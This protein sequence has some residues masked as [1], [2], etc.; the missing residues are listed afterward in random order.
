MM[1]QSPGSGRL[2]PVAQVSVGPG[3]QL[4]H[5]CVSLLQSLLPGVWGKVT[6]DMIKIKLHFVLTSLHPL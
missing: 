5:D 4:P 6:C 1:L 3:H 2:S